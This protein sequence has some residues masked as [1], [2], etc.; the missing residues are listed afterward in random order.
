MA[1]PRKWRKVCKMPDSNMFGP[2]EAN[3][4]EEGI[5]KMTVD[6]Y[7]TIRLIDYE[8]FSQEECARQMNVGR[9]TA[10]GIYTEARKKLA[11]VLV[12]SKSLLIEGGSYTLCD[13]LGEGKGCGRGCHRNDR[14]KMNI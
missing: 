5:V 2:L 13:G 3:L 10:Q 6:E 7:E 12:N 8:G 1:R 4:N 9:T 14:R 11:D